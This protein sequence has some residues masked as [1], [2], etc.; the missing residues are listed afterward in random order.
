MYVRA[1]A[2]RRAYAAAAGACLIMPKPTEPAPAIFAPGIGI[3]EEGILVLARA[4]EAREGAAA[5][6]KNAATEALKP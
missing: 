5:H 4:V 2:R 6:K 3:L 1:R